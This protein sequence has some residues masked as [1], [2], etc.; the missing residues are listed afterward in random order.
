[1]LGLQPAE[2]AEAA[3]ISIADVERIE[4]GATS[5]DTALAAIRQAL[6][7][8]GIIFEA[9]GE[10]I[11]GGPGVRLAQSA[12]KSFDTVETEVVQYPE[13]MKNDAPPGAGG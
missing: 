3:G 10:L 2:L 9:D 8:A 7:A 12:G 5:A 4:R 6:E 11:S 13:F 1:M